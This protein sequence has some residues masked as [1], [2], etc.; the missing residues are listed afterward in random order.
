MNEM[1]H[2]L[3]NVFLFQVNLPTAMLIF[4]CG[5]VNRFKEKYLDMVIQVKLTVMLVLATL[6][7]LFWLWLWL[8]ICDIRHDVTWCSLSKFW[9]VFCSFLGI[10]QSLP[11]TSYIKLI[12]IWMLFTMIYPFAEI[13]VLCIEDIVKAKQGAEAKQSLYSINLKIRYFML[14]QCKVPFVH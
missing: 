2:D 1:L 5:I 14:L 8:W 12:E 10:S 3:L 11:S 9:N 7:V 4:L 13:V 6:W